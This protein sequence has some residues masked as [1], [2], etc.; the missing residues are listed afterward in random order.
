MN[1]RLKRAILYVGL[2]VLIMLI[3]I[4]VTHAIGMRI[5]VTSSMPEGVYILDNHQNIQ[6]GSIVSV[7]L[8]E[9]VAKEAIDKGYI[10]KNR[11]CPN[12]SEPLIKEVIATPQDQVMVTPKSMIVT[13]DKGQEIYKAP[14]HKL[15]LS[16]IPIKHFIDFGKQKSGYWVYGRGNPDLSWDSRYFGG[17]QKENIKQVLKPIWIWST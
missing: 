7:C 9:N 14:N 11:F 5:N 8:P 6:V 12:G 17:V 10:S 15:S 4:V 3:F 2:P 13:N 16:G 1:A